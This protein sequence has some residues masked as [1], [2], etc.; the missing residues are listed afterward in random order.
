MDNIQRHIQLTYK[1]ISP[2]L[3]PDEIERQRILLG[4]ESFPKEYDYYI[5]NI[6]STLIFKNIKGTLQFHQDRYNSIW[7][8]KQEY[9]VSTTDFFEQERKK[10]HIGSISIDNIIDEINSRNTPIMNLDEDLSVNL[11]SV[12]E[13]LHPNQFQIINCEE[14]TSPISECYFK[15]CGICSISTHTT[16]HDES[17]LH[18][19]VTLKRSFRKST[20]YDEIIC[21]ECNEAIEDNQ[22]R[23]SC[24]LCDLDYHENCFKTTT[25]EHDMQLGTF[26]EMDYR[27]CPA[28]GTI[29]FDDLKCSVCSYEGCLKYNDIQ[30]KDNY[31]DLKGSKGLR[32]SNNIFESDI[33]IINGHLK[34]WVIAKITNSCYDNKPFFVIFTSFIEYYN[35]RCKHP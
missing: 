15:F 31:F 19:P 29:S 27:S 3:T 23:Y 5:R 1:D 12:T 25:C 22:K 17:C 35:Y 33:L 2:P 34:G 32:I 16:C 20:V 6:S 10:F 7:V 21:N 4:I 13:V 18:C 26:E 9:D 28:C 8:K 11:D 14:C 30:F 24:R